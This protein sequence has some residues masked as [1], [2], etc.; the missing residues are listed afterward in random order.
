MR[1]AARKV[2]KS[3]GD[4]I[5]LP[6]AEASVLAKAD[7]LFAVLVNIIKT[8]ASGTPPLSLLERLID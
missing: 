2:A 6:I 1:K 3:L 5:E 7:L 8:T 4:V